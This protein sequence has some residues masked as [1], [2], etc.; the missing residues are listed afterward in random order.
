MIHQGF[1]RFGN[2]FLF[3]PNIPRFFPLRGVSRILFTHGRFRELQLIA[4]A[5][6]AHKMF[7]PVLYIYLIMAKHH[8]KGGVQVDAIQGKS[9]IKLIRM[10]QN[11]CREKDLVE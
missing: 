9:V 4:S 7:D 5:F 8:L 3:Y 11:F 6:F 10:E 1:I 2:T